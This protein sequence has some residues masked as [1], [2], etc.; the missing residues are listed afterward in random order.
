MADEFK[1][2]EELLQGHHEAGPALAQL[3]PER[4]VRTRVIEHV[5]H[6]SLRAHRVGGRSAWIASMPESWHSLRYGCRSASVFELL[7]PDSPTAVQPVAHDTAFS[8]LNVARAGAGAVW[9]VQV[10]PSQYSISGAVALEPVCV[11]T[12]VHELAEA[13]LTPFSELL[14]L[15]PVLG[16][17]SGV[18][19]VPV[20]CDAR[21]RE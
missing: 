10:V 3:V 16:S 15:V 21:A 4:F 8:W 19:A 7:P 14:L 1:L 9:M 12:A 18:H 13:Q 20:H 5:S 2:V 17:V 6:D 11:P